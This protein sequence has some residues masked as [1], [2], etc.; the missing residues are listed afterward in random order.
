MQVVQSLLANERP[1]FWRSH[2]PPFA[3]ASP[4]VLFDCGAVTASLDPLEQATT[5][6]A[7]VA[8]SAAES[9][10]HD[11]MHAARAALVPRIRAK[12]AGVFASK[13]DHV[14][15]TLDHP[16]RNSRSAP[17]AENYGTPRFTRGDGASGRIGSTRVVRSKGVTIY[18]ALDSDP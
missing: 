8:H 18:G 1:D 4:P 10:I 15:T 9:E 2:A 11:R 7:R 13:V 14:E 17:R 12:F 6:S 5:R 3:P 16:P